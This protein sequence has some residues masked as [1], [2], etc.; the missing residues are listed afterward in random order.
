MCPDALLW[1]ARGAVIV[2]HAAVL[3]C[4]TCLGVLLIG[5]PWLIPGKIR[6]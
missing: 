6:H 4:E 1:A 3:D 2:A 5:E